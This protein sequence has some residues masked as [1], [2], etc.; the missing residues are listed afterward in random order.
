MYEA[1]IAVVPI[2]SGLGEWEKARENHGNS[3]KWNYGYKRIFDCELYDQ[4]I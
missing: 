4:S 1:V 2:R 3:V